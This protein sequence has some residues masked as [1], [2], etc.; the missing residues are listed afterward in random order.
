MVKKEEEEEKLIILTVQLYDNENL[1]TGE[2]GFFLWSQRF[3]Y[4]KPESSLKVKS[5]PFPPFYF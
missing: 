2:S 1:F 5:K 3:E 4:I